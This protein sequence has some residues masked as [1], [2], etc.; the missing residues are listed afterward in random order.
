MASDTCIFAL[1]QISNDFGC[2][3]GESVTRRTGPDIACNSM[4]NLQQCSQIYEQFKQVGLA[5]FG[6]EDDLTQVPHGIWAK[7]QYG[8][9]LGL[10]KEV[11]AGTDEAVVEDIAALINAAEEQF[12]HIDQLPYQNLIPAMQAYRIKR[13]RSR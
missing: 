4:H 6:Y 7:I 9:L 12:Q 5:E 3:H 10:Q 11:Q 2:E 1:T 8:G 13:R